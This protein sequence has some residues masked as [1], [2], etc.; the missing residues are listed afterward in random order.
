MKWFND[1][2][3]VVKMLKGKKEGNCMLNIPS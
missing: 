2:Q 3:T 1:E